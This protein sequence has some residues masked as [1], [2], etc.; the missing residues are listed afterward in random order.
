MNAFVPHVHRPIIYP[1]LLR[2]R[3]CAS[4]GI[5]TLDMEPFI[6]R[7]RRSPISL[8]ILRERGTL[9]N[10]LIYQVSCNLMEHMPLLDFVGVKDR[11]T[12][13]LALWHLLMCL[14]RIGQ[15]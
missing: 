13:H 7:Q 11:E 12:G 6:Q 14:H 10:A 1:P 15:R 3:W 5:V 2:W 9:V 8:V 4:N